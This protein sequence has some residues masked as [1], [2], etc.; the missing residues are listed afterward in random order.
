MSDATRQ[1]VPAVRAEKKGGR[2]AGRAPVLLEWA[3]GLSVLVVG[4]TG[5]AVVGL[6]ILAGVALWMAV[7]RAGL[8]VLVLGALLWFLNYRIMHGVL[9]AALQDARERQAAAE[10]APGPEAAS[11]GMEWKA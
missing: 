9:E 6:S 7:I 5:L 8:L 1:P 11:L 4:L 10:G 2:A 3:Y